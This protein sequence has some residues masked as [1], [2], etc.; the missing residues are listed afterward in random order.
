MPRPLSSTRQPPSAC[1]MTPMRD[2][3]PAIASSTALS[4]T[5]TIR[6]WR[7]SLPVPPMY[8]P[9][10]L[11]TGSRPSSTWISSA[12]YFEAWAISVHPLATL[13][14]REGLDR[15]G[16]RHHHEARLLDDLMALAAAA[17]HLLRV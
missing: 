7:P 10:R 3:K 6:W 5:S 9:G 11:R 17:R 2:A 12:G 16:L 15:H 13:G 1:R 4:T 14:V 8:M